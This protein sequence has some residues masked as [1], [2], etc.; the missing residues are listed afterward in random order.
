MYYKELRKYN[1][2]SDS[3]P[4]DKV[5]FIKMLYN[6]RIKTYTPETIKA[7]WK[8]TGNHPISKR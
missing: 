8:R 6:A 7:S 1:A 2:L 3:T 4:V 5:N